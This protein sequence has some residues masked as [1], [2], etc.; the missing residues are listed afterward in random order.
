M[1]I[2]IPIT[3]FIINTLI[4]QISVSRYEV[5]EGKITEVQITLQDLKGE[6]ARDAN[7]IAIVGN[8]SVKFNQAISGIYLANITTVNMSLG[9]N[10]VHIK[11]E[12]TGYKQIEREIEIYVFISGD[13]NLDNI[14]DYKDLAILGRL[15][16]VKHMDPNFDMR[17]DLNEDGRINYK[18]LAILASTM[19]ERPDRLNVTINS[20]FILMGFLGNGCVTLQTCL[21]EY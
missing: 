19:G 7:V 18:D 13:I 11:I 20:I 10:V 14:V 9:R 3:I 4:P 15:Y 5:R 21:K 17:A 1:D 2:D 8:A 12:K 16:G 6:L